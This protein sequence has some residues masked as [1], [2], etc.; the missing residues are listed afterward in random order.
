LRLGKAG[1]PD[2]TGDAEEPFTFGKVRLLQKGTD[3]CIIAYGSIMKLAFDLAA[4]V[5]EK[6]GVRPAVMSAHTLKPLDTEGLAS[7]LQ[8]FDHVVALEEHSAYGGLGPQLKQIA[9]DSGARCKLHTFSLQDSFI[10][11]FGS[12]KDLWDAHGLTL[13]RARAAIGV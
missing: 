6:A 11:L 13:D 10:H 7:L 2:L 3:I 4:R 5:A 9:W 8:Q 12:Q 1:E